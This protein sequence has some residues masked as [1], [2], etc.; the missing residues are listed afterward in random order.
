MI[1]T[2]ENQ[3]LYLTS[4][5]YNAARIISKLAEIVI[6]NGGKVAPHN[7]A[8]ISNRHLNEAIKDYS[9][10]VEAAQKRV[11]SGEATE[12]TFDYLKRNK[13]MLDSALKAKNEP[14]AVTH[15]TYIDFVL[16]DVKYYYQVDDNPFFQFYYIKTPVHNRVYSKD[17]CM[18][19]DAKEWLFDCFFG[20]SATDDD[21]AQAAQSIYDFLKSAKNTQ[22]IIDKERVKV[23]N[24]Y[25]DG[26]HLETRFKKERT[27]KIDY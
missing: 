12:T 17:A 19:E 3:R 16:N 6:D 23:P 8:I 14:I 1:V 9:Q 13:M 10:K 26:Y 15:T 5:N 7:T 18:E 4:W 25:N 22:I 24:T 11:D 2:S 27:G 21:I 20:F